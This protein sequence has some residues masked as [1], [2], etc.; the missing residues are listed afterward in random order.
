MRPFALLFGAAVGLWFPDID[1]T[2]PLLDHRSVVTHSVLPALLAALWLPRALAAGIAMGVAVTLTADLFPE[3]W[4]GF[5]TI[6]LPLF[7]SI[8]GASPVWLGLNAVAAMAVAH[9]CAGLRGAPTTARAGTAAW[10]IGPD[11]MLFA[12]TAGVAA[13]YIVLGE[14][15]LVPLAAVLAVWVAGRGMARWA[16]AGGR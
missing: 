8:A 12:V 1:Q 11:R 10:L 2:V 7:G 3:R 13:V 5:A 14:G 16:P 9:R 4:V 15:K 6:H